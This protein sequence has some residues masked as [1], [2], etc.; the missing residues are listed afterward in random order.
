MARKDIF[1]YTFASPRTTKNPRYGEYPNIF[2]I[3]GKMDIVPQVPLEDWGYE[4]YGTDLST[5]AQETDSDY[6]KLQQAANKVYHEIIGTDFD[7]WNNVELNAQLKTVLSYILAISPTNEVYAEHMEDHIVQIYGERDIANILTQVLAM[8]N[9]SEFITPENIEEASA[10][11]DYIT[12]SVAG[13]VTR[14]GYAYSNWHAVGIGANLFHEHNPDVYLA[15]L[16]SSDDPASIF[17]DNGFYYRFV[18]EGD[19]N[20]VLYDEEIKV[21]QQMDNTGTVQYEFNNNETS[22]LSTTPGE[23]THIFMLRA[24]GRSICVIPCDK[25]YHLGIIANSDQTVSF[26]EVSN[27]VGFTE[28]AVSKQISLDMKQGDEQLADILITAGEYAEHSGESLESFYT[29]YRQTELSYSPGL[30]TRL[31]NINVFGLSWTQ[32]L[33]VLGLIIILVFTLIVTICMLLG[34]RHDRKIQ[35]M[36][37]EKIPTSVPL[38]SV[39]WLFIVFMLI[40]LCYVMSE[41][42]AYRFG[43]LNPVRIFFKV[44]ATALVVFIAL[45]ATVRTRWLRDVVVCFGLILC[46]VGDLLLNIMPLPGMIAFGLAHVVF[47]TAFIA[48]EHPSRTQVIVWVTFVVVTIVVCILIRSKV[49]MYLIPAMIYASLLWALLVFGWRQPPILRLA[50]V[51]FILSD[52]MTAWATLYGLGQTPFRTLELA[53]YY[54]AIYLF[55]YEIWRR[56]FG[57]KPAHILSTKAPA[58]VAAESAAAQ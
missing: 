52:A 16:F 3:V 47:L 8:A 23:Q 36:D 45:S 6:Y 2:N 35:E 56:S 58:V 19:V 55:A 24:G 1:A 15:W 37:I 40:V 30:L 4:R 20:L 14:S 9:D 38:P 7:F 26:Y 18:V 57:P 13:F 50:I 21:L 53:F 46:C 34:R 48:D 42:L 43:T 49:G 32:M 54:A 11:L 31:E 41:V 39:H 33:L 5:P 27:Y 12:A 28:G 25:K 10:L 22:A 17:S 44:T 51:F 29:G